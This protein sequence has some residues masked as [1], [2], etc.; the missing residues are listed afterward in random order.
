MG[1]ERDPV[2]YLD[3][4]VAL[5]RGGPA[6]AV[7]EQS[8][9]AV[10]QAAVAARGTRGSGVPIHEQL[11]QALREGIRSGRLGAGTRL[12]SSRGLASRLGVSRGVVSEAY[13]QL[14]AEGYLTTRQGAPVRVSSAVRA[15]ERHPPARSLLPSFSYDLRPSL[16]DLAGFPRDRWQRSLR[17]A[18]RESSLSAIGYPDPRGTPELRSALSEY[19]ARVRGAA[20]E[21][22]HVLVCT[23][24]MQGLSLLCRLL[25]G[26]GVRVVA[27]EDP[28]WHN[29]R[30]I[31]E[32]AGLQVTPVPVD[33]E[34]LDVEALAGSDAS[35]VVLT[36]AHQFP[37]G[38]VLSPRRRA[39]LIEWAE[40]GEHL[41]VEDD[42]DG[43]LRFDRGAI[44]ALQGLA[45][46]RVLY[47]GSASKRLAPAMR[48][49]WLL[50]PS[51]ISWQLAAV[52]TIEDGGS[53]AIGQLALADF[54]ARGELDRHLRRTRFTYERRRE[55]LLA[56]IA[57]HLPWASATG[58]PCGLF[59]PVRLPA[60][61]DEAA[62]L[63]AAA[64]RGLG[65]EGAS[66]HRFHSGGDPCLLLGYGSLAEPA[67]DRG[68]RLL[69]EV[70]AQLD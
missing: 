19:L 23:G 46:E 17:S 62:L 51:W 42:Y 54:I 16:P 49:G 67:L 10:E 55:A 4:L 39:A 61:T 5:E 34:G 32:Q 69:A 8:D 53:E 18:L 65:V 63:S 6:R 44:G 68:M 21:P 37:T 20:A 25:A 40:S 7:G 3:L 47:A 11:E 70:F 14:A 41:I 59:E 2:G 56:A 52:K 48:L 60:G 31:V 28:G 38:V 43:E 27:L 30:L 22:E 24:F 15:L 64:D 35:V 45:P 33:E 1:S 13:G 36:P 29:H 12:P 26:Q 57:R 66:L 9:G 58:G 50:A